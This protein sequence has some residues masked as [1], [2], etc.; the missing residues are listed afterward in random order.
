VTTLGCWR[1]SG[2]RETETGAPRTV[3]ISTRRI[4]H[5]TPKP[6]HQPEGKPARREKYIQALS[7]QQ[8]CSNLLSL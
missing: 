6:E 3:F 5:T 2:Q 7:L 4:Q 1:R 8:F